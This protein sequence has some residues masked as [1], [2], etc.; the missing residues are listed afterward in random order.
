[1]SKSSEAQR[2][3]TVRKLTAEMQVLQERMN[4][5]IEQVCD[6]LAGR[7]LAEAITAPAPAATLNGNVVERAFVPAFLN[8]P[9]PSVYESNPQSG[10][11][12]GGDCRMFSDYKTGTLQLLQ[13]PSRR[14]GSE[15]R[16]GL[17]INHADF[18]GSFLSLVL[19]ARAL[20]GGLPSGRARVGMVFDARSL[21][22]CPLFAKCAWKIGEQWTEH[23]L[24]TSSS[25]LTVSSFDIPALDPSKVD[26]LDFHFIFSPHARGTIEIQRLS[27]ALGVEAPPQQ[28]QESAAAAG[29]FESAP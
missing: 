22:Q 17:I 11:Q 24:E 1:M 21:P 9:A 16:Y 3:A 14:G 28:P 25:R 27:I 2:L 6:L 19:D 18:D 7:E 4:Q 5:T 26:A 13:M 15:A 12:L 20:L 23:R 8:V 29:V 10:Y